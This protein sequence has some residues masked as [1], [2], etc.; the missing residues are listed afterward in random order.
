MRYRKS[1]RRVRISPACR[2]PQLPPTFPQVNARNVGDCAGIGGA[3]VGA[4]DRPMSTFLD[5]IDEISGSESQS[6]IARIAG[7]DQSN[8]SRWKK[9]STP[10][11]EAVIRLAQ[12]FRRPVPEALHRA[13]LISQE[14]ATSLRVTNAPGLA[15]YPHAALLRELERRLDRMSPAPEI[16][17]ETE[18]EDPNPDDYDLA[19]GHVQRPD[20][21]PAD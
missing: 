9:G 13:G 17:S 12:H 1:T 2:Q 8:V 6:T 3:C 5:Y 4:Y 19:A 21:R 14:T 15:D 7:V 10:S 16:I 18:Q 20:D 11:P